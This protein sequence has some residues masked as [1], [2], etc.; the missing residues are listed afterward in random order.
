M[1]SD[2]RRRCGVE[3]SAAFGRMPPRIVRKNGFDAAL[4]RVGGTLRARHTT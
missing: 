3:H 1:V 4:L 2:G